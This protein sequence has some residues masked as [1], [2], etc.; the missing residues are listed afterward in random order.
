MGG[1]GSWEGWFED[2]GVG[3]ECKREQEGVVFHYNLKDGKIWWQIFFLI[4][5]FRL[6]VNF[7]LYNRLLHGK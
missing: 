4:F 6:F 2:E 5:I 7:S 1:G 3:K